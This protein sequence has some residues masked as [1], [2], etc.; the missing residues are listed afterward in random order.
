MSTGPRRASSRGTGRGLRA[1]ASRPG[2]LIWDGLASASELAVPSTTMVGVAV[3]TQTT[4]DSMFQATIRRMVGSFTLKPDAVDV[5]VEWRMG[6][7]V[8]NGDAFVAGAFPD[9]Y[10]DA[11][12]WLH[13]DTG[14][15]TVS[16]LEDGSQYPR[17]KLDTKVMRKMPQTDTVLAMI[18]HSITGTFNVWFGMKVLYQS[19]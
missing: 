1:G 12:P 10:A 8:M 9:P 5:D 16:D 11:V 19:K 13:E 14:E 18:W 3:L 17:F 7:I 6:L 15:F 2:R 4:S